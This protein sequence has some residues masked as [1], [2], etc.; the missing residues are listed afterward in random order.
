MCSD[1]YA[2]PRERFLQV[3]VGLGL[4]LA[5]CLSSGIYNCG[6][7]LLTVDQLQVEYGWWYYCVTVVGCLST[8]SCAFITDCIICVTEEGRCNSNAWRCGET[9]PD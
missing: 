1:R 4:G 6:Q 7:L 9:I 2:P 5:F 8:Y 3:T